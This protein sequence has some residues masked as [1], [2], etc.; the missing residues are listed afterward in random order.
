MLMKIKQLIIINL[1]LVFPMLGFAQLD[2]QFQISGKNFGELK[3]LK[4]NNPSF[5]FLKLS[6]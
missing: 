1:F 3:T 6:P 4:V 5:S 2:E